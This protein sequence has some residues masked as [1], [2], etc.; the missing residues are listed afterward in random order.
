MESNNNEV[1]YSIVES[2]ELE[3]MPEIYNKIGGFP[4]IIIYYG[5]NEITY[6]GPRNK[7]RLVEFINELK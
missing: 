3:K 5:N 2:K 1:I 4:T 7:E 6:N